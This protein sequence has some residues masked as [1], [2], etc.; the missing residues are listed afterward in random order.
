MQNRSTKNEGRR[1]SWSMRTA[2]LKVC[3][4]SWCAERKRCLRS[5]CCTRS[6]ITC[7]AGGRSR[8]QNRERRTHRPSPHVLR[9]LFKGYRFCRLRTRLFVVVRPRRHLRSPS[10]ADLETFTASQDDGAPAT[11]CAKLL[12]RPQ[13]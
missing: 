11:S 8:N 13:D 1:P 2:E 3:G 12:R 5:P 10:D 4:S 6:R 9:Q 7:A